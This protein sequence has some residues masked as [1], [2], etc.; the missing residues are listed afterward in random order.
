MSQT[1]KTPLG[2]GVFLVQTNVMLLV[3]MK[4]K[5]ILISMIIVIAAIVVVVALA[6]M[7]KFNYLANQPGYDVDGNKIKEEQIQYEDKVSEKIQVSVSSEDGI[8]YVG[9]EYQINWSNYYGNENLIIS[10]LL[11]GGNDEGVDSE[12][13]V[14][15]ISNTGSYIWKVLPEN[16]NHRYR[17]RVYPPGGREIFGQSE[18]ITVLKK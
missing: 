14:T 17:V 18:I 13:L 5:K 2:T 11:I 3:F 8:V 15:D 10:L 12:I 16:F 4:T 1:K 9:N 6:G 7:Y